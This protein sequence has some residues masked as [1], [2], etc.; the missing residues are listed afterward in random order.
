MIDVES[1]AFA[2]LTAVRRV[3]AIGAVHGDSERL[4]SLHE[5]IAARVEP[6]DRFVYLGNLIGVGPGILDTVDEAL[7]FR[8]RMFVPG[9]EPGDFVYLR[10]AQ[11]EMWQKLLQMQFAPNPREV[12]EWMMKQ[13][14]DATLEAYG[15]RLDEARSLLGE[16][17]IAVTRWTNGLRASMQR[18]AGHDD[19]LNSV[20]RAAYTENK[21]LLFVHAGI[22]PNRPLSQQADALWWGSGYF[23]AMEGLYGD[24]QMVVRGFDRKHAGLAMNKWTATVDA[25]CGYGGRLATACFHPDG[26]ASDWIEI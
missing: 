16:G 1:D 8:R 12:F 20:K 4:K 25:G 9:M 24:V 23:S 10:G 22:D 2:K 11:E 5:E 6:G 14:V 7:A 18:R 3:W 15:G 19:L 13:G 17:A 21:R 26:S